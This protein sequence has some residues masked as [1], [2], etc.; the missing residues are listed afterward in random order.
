MAF[1][2]Y[3]FF[4]DMDVKDGEDEEPNEAM[5]LSSDE[6]LD[7]KGKKVVQYKMIDGDEKVEE[8]KKEMTF[9]SDK[10]V[11]TYYRKYGK[12]IGFVVLRRCVKS[13]EDGQLRY[14]ILTCNCDGANKEGSNTSNAMKPTPKMNITGCCA[15]ICATR[16]DNGTWYLSKVVLEH[17]YILSPSKARF[18]RCYKKINSSTRKRIEMN[19]IAGIRVYKNFNSLVVEIG[20][21]ENLPFGEKDC[22]NF[23]NKA[24]ELRLDKGGGQALCDYF[25]KMR[26]QNDGFYY[27][28]DIDDNCRLRNV[29]WADARSRAAYEFF[30]GCHYIC[31]DIFD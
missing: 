10:E 9:S 24:R 5:M 26:D 30:G 31:H 27:V 21:F 25:H 14:M 23:I 28:M 20:E 1:N 11:D 3:T 2:L 19:D 4:I 12:Q 15:R 7:D 6:E 16:C 29:F 18:Y 17:N 22:R 13:D 8:P